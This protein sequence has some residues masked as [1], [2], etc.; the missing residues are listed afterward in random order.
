MV[1]KGRAQEHINGEILYH[2]ESR[3]NTEVNNPYKHRY[4]TLYVNCLF[5]GSAWVMEPVGLIWLYHCLGMNDL[6][7]KCSP[8]P[9]LS[10][11]GTL[12]WVFASVPSDI[13]TQF[14]G[15]PKKD[16]TPRGYPLNKMSTT[17]G[18]SD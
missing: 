1:H 15:L 14:G 2:L 9:V 10:S 4:N 17:Y 3:M 5:D 12:R 7:I 18:S 8:A 13:R 11:H 6:F 16:A